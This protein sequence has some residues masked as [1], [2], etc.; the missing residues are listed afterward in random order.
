M[1]K[2]EG[3]QEPRCARSEGGRGALGYYLVVAAVAGRGIMGVCGDF[4]SGH[5]SFGRRLR[6]TFFLIC[7]FL[8]F[9]LLCL[10]LHGPFFKS[11]KSL[12]SKP[13]KTP[14]GVFSF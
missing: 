1:H 12:K 7:V 6:C 5:S 9:F 2:R 4:S 11:L 8:F 14:S 10:F 13:W 3:A